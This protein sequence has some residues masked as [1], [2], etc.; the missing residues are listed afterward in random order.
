MLLAK[1]A[2]T[3]AVVASYDLLQSM[4]VTIILEKHAATSQQDINLQQ[5]ADPCALKY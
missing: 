5:Q 2:S 3:L 1:L 4:Q